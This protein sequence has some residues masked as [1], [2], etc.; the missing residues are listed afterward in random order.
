MPVLSLLSDRMTSPHRLLEY[1]DMD[2]WSRWGKA[3]SPEGYLHRSRMLA[4]INLKIKLF[5]LKNDA[6]VDL[7][8]KTKDN[9][10]RPC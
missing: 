10:K 8:I 5:V 3:S 6:I 9:E 7:E 4:A 2:V 1:K